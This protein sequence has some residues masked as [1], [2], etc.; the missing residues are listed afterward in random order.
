MGYEWIKRFINPKY[1]ETT[2]FVTAVSILAVVLIFKFDNYLMIVGTFLVYFT[3]PL[4]LGL[5]FSLYHGIA[6]GK[7]HAVQKEFMVLFIVIV[8]TLASASATYVIIDQA[9]LKYSDQQ[10]PSNS[11]LVNHYFEI[12][13][14]S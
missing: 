6:I 11:T 5:V 9:S 7:K 13:S 14:R 4:L 10:A 1:S 8:N 2:L 12:T 3:V